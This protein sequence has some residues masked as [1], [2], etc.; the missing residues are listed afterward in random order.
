M[1][2]P[3]WNLDLADCALPM[4]WKAIGELHSYFSDLVT[5]NFFSE[6]SSP[7]V[8]A[9]YRFAVVYKMF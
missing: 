4:V 3:V 7:G 5:R 8:D 1:F 2:S 6:S 9:M